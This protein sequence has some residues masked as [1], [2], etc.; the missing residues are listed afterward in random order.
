M[1]LA[2]CGVEKTLM[3]ETAI[4]EV[5]LY[6]DGPVTEKKKGTQTG[7]RPFTSAEPGE[8]VCVPFSSLTRTRCHQGANRDESSWPPWSRWF[9]PRVMPARGMRQTHQIRDALEAEMG[10]LSTT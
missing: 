3:V 5:I 4:W 2:L 1:G 10:H 8:K 9:D 6:A 7:R